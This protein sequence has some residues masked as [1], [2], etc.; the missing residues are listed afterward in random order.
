MG[1]GG[2]GRLPTGDD[3]LPTTN[4]L[5]REVDW[6]ERGREEKRRD[7]VGREGGRKRGG[8]VS[9][10]KKV[11]TAGGVATSLSSL[12]GGG[13]VTPESSSHGTWRENA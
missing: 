11:L 9:N 4:Q 12:C 5:R 7:R 2:G 13:E 6:R 8:G 1:E 3:K 10:E